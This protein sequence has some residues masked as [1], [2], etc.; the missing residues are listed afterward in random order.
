[1]IENP[2]RDA[3]SHDDPFDSL[4]DPETLRTREDVPF[5]HDTLEHED[6]EHCSSDVAGRVAAGVTDEDG[7]LLLLC[8]DDLGIAIL[9][10]GSVDPGEDWFA[11][12]REE[13]EGQTGIEIAIDG[14]ELVR[15]IDHVVEGE[16][17]TSTYGIV[18]EGS[19]IGGEIQ[20]CKLSGDAGSDDWRAG[21]FDGLPE[22]VEVPDGG[23]GEDLALFFK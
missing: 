11:V 7:R 21:W 14:V 8:N 6:E 1:V 18:F 19:P 17:H 20:D 9:P 3:T 13:I 23:P 15:D 12:A 2:E 4:T 22:G 16:P 5:S 10:H